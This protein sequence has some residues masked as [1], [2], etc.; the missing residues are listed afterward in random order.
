MRLLQGSNDEEQWLEQG[1]CCVNI[2]DVGVCL[3]HKRE[4]L[5]EEAGILPLAVTPG[6][7]R[8]TSSEWCTREKG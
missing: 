1:R 3:P 2:Y 8:R 6:A 5:R 4:A 7:E